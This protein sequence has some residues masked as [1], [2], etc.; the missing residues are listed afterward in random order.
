MSRK[1]QGYSSYKVVYAP[2]HQGLFTAKDATEGQ[3]RCDRNLYHD[4]MHAGI[5][6]KYLPMSQQQKE[7]GTDV[8][9]AVDALQ[10][11]LDGKIDV[12]VLV[13]GDGDF[14]PLVRALNK[15][16]IR[17]LAAFFDFED[18]DYVKTYGQIAGNTSINTTIYRCF[19]YV[20][21]EDVPAFV[22]KFRKQS[23]DE[24]QVMHTFREL[25]LGAFLG[26]Q[27]LKP[28]YEFAVGTK[29]PDWCI[30]DEG[31]NVICAIELT[32]FHLDRLS[33]NQI[34]TA[35]RK[36]RMWSGVLGPNDDRLYQR[37]RAKAGA[38]SALFNERRVPYVIALFG[39]FTAAINS[40]ELRAC[41]FD[42]NGLFHSYPS[43]T[44]VLCFEESG[45][46]YAFT[47]VR[48]PGRPLDIALPSGI[49]PK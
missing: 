29:T 8:A 33:E 27:G 45:R 19:K 47:Y 34:M 25:I 21:T 30:L 4:L 48:N 41:L 35:L 49:F 6:A 10:I 13:T 31:S 17:V 1:E 28:K 12:A 42:E 38:Y 22:K 3:L 39:E 20:S 7:K 15:Q 37:L 26:Y 46:Q 32:N 18:G 36:G 40:D 23:N 43:I 44:G 14:V 16:G 5:E 11:G 24:I 2:W 9:M